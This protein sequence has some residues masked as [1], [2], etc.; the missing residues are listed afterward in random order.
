[1]CAAYSSA[2]ANRRASRTDTSRS[3]GATSASASPAAMPSKTMT[4]RISISVKPRG[5]RRP[6]TRRAL[7]IPGTDVRIGAGAAGL[8]VGTVRENVDVALEPRIEV[9]I[10]VPPRVAWQLFQVTAGFPVGRQRGVGGLGDERAQPLL[11]RRIT[12]VVETIELERLADCGEIAF[13][14]HVACVVGAGQHARHDERGEHTEDH[15]D[16]HDLDQRE[17]AGPA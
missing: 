12:L 6:A 13:R 2:P 8:A 10:R 11:G 15:D 5:P 17:A 14:G 3:S 16:D 7:Q 9:L 4:T 1:R